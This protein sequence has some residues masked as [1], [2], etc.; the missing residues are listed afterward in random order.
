MEELEPA[1][2]AIKPKFQ[3][4]LKISD[5]ILTSEV[6]KDFLA[7]ILTLGNFINMVIVDGISQLYLNSY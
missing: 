1:I 5:K 6:L 7:Y 4:I 2:Q 3:S